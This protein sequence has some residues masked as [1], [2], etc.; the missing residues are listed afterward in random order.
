MKKYI[1]PEI[2]IIEI[3]IVDVLADST[4]NPGDDN[5]GNDNLTPTG[6][7]WND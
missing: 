7:W 6:E 4:T 3:S 2:D 1:Y 5:K